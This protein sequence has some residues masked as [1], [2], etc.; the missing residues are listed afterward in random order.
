[1]RNALT[2][3]MLALGVALLAACDI[4]PSDSEWDGARFADSAQQLLPSDGAPDSVLSSAP[5]GCSM[6]GGQ[7]CGGWNPAGSM[8]APRY[9]H[10]ATLLLNGRVLVAGGATASAEV[11][12]PPPEPGARQ[13]P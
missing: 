3:W 6:P 8:A 11:Y 5:Q 10:T 13:V 2:R 4:S 7:T 1:M 9:S 12:A